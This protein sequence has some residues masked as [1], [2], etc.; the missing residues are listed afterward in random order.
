MANITTWKSVNWVAFIASIL[1]AFNIFTNFDSILNFVGLFR[2]LVDNW[3]R[4]VDW[5]WEFVFAVF[6][7]ELEWTAGEKHQA[8]SFLL[9]STLVLSAIY[10]SRI[11]RKNKHS[12]AI[13]PTTEFKAFGSVIFISVVGLI[14]LW[15]P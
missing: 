13:W 9:I 3:Q 8:L 14:P 6:G 1:A 7:L 4:W 10:R 15:L 5:F 11:V 2:S 12:Y